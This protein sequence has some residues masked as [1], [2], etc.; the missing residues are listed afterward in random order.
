LRLE[1]SPVLWEHQEP[2]KIEYLADHPEFV[3]TLAAWHRREWGHLRPDETL[4]MRSAKLSLSQQKR[5][6]S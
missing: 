2:L 5:K 6:A 1:D 4:E 3:P